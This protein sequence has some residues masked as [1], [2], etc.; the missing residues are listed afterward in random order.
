MVKTLQ[1]ILG[2]F[3]RLKP[4]NAAAGD[5]PQFSI[6]IPICHPG[7][8]LQKSLES[9]LAQ[10]GVTIQVL[11][12]EYGECPEA[13]AA[14]EAFSGDLT[15]ILMDAPGVYRGMNE[16]IAKATGRIFYFLGAGDRLR[17]GIL[18]EIRAA[19]HWG[20][21]L[22]VYGDVFMEDLQI[23]YDGPFDAK[24]LRK[25][26]ICHQAIFYSRRVFERHGSY[27][28][29]YPL[30]A[31]YAYNLRAFGDPG[32][33]KHYHALTI[34]DYEGGGLSA[35]GQDEAFMKDRPGLN[36]RYL[37]LKEGKA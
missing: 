23:I 24:K 28:L 36:Q 29:R 15:H 27:D 11:V 26:N 32:T 8:K 34:A 18:A 31:D 13:R 14:M 7:A 2:R 19:Y 37:P 10:P 30:L 17:P 3:R 9:L 1:S 35:N 16:G 22:L 5:T 6:I 21:S 4:S 20:G 12:A 33:E 25:K